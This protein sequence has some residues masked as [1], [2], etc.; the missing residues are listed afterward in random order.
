MKGM[1][2]LRAELTDHK[3]KQALQAEAAGFIQYLESEAKNT[4]RHY[5]LSSQ[6]LYF[7]DGGNRFDYKKSGKVIVRQKNGGGYVTVCF[8][9]TQLKLKSNG[10]G[11]D[12]SL[13]LEKDG[14]T[15]AIHTTIFPY[16]DL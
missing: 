7:Y 14:Q 15:W 16:V 9:V 4:S 10:K 13:I 1:L 5:L 12:L 3:V 11:T 6:H 8:Y 2:M